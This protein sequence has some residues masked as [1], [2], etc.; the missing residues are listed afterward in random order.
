LAELI[1]A[2]LKRRIE[3]F[4]Q[5]HLDSMLDDIRKL[6][7]VRSIKA[8]PEPGKPYG[9]GPAEALE[10]FAAI[11]EGHGFKANNVDGYVL[12]V[13][14]NEKPDK[15]GILC[16][17]DIVHE[18]SGWSSPPYEMTI[19]DGRIY[20]RG[21]SDNKG[22]AVASLYALL[23]VRELGIPM[24]GNVRLM[25]GTD[26]ENGSSDLV[27]YFKRAVP[28]P[29]CFSPDAAFPVYNIEKGRYAPKFSASYPE[30]ASLPRVISVKAGHAVNIVPDEAEAVVEG[31][32]KAKLSE[33]L[34]LHSSKT[35]VDFEVT[36]E[37]SRVVI[38]A[39]GLSCHASYPWE[40]K[41]TV[42][43]LIGF[44]ANQSFAACEGFDRLKA[45]AELIPFGDHYGEAL[46]IKMEDELS[47]PLTENLGIF[48]YG[49]TGLKGGLDFRC[50]ICSTEDNTARAV[51]KI[52]EKN[53]L[54]I[55]GDKMV[56]PHHVP[57]ELPFIKTLLS[58][59]EEYT[60]LKG[61]CVSMG[62]GTYVHGIENSVAF[63]AAFPDTETYA[64]A[65]DEYAVISELEACVKIFAQV[66]VDMCK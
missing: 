42:T 57:E 39:K 63:G 36:E 19:K 38:R 20:G 46:G 55:D 10:A 40:G 52:F 56:L 62:G 35:G 9:P 2:D 61:E 58:S 8:D 47:G 14:L 28:P 27:E 6:I 25:L 44:L 23:C 60:G 29:F 59:Y 4:A 11:A 5:S 18:G 17:L 50:P 53:N 30:S 7:A 34:A 37:G 43:A 41:N 54:R 32:D 31:M 3:A 24:S 51:E 65:A 26:E 48:E 45:V 12:E 15:L 33:S 49:L 22:P 1:K 16:H 66:I 64:H 13:N 21:S